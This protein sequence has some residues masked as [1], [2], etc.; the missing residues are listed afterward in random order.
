MAHK[1]EFMRLRSL[2]ITRTVAA[3]FFQTQAIIV[4][5]LSQHFYVFILTKLTPRRISEK[6]TA[7]IVISLYDSATQMTTISVCGKVYV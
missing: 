3:R 4:H 1:R 2:K 5:S 6:D 7:F